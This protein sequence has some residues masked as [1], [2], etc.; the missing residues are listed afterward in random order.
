M[1][2]VDCAGTL[3]L[4][5]QLVSCSGN[6]DRG[7]AEREIPVKVVRITSVSSVKEQNYVGVV[8]EKASSSLILVREGQ[9]VNKG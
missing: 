1:K 4:L 7:T 6:G 3:L 8:E 9:Q 5:L 2:I